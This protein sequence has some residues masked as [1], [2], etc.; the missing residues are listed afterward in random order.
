MVAVIPSE[1]AFKKLP[2]LKS[3]LYSFDWKI[4]IKAPFVEELHSKLVKGFKAFGLKVLS[5]EMGSF[6]R[7]KPAYTLY[8]KWIGGKQYKGLII[9]VDLVLAVKINTHSSTMKV[10]FKSQAGSVVSSLLGTLPCYFAVSGYKEYPVT[11]H[12]TCSRNLRRSRKKESWPDFQYL[13][14]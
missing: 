5:D 10:D 13:S 9:A 7:H 11:A 4:N 14:Q 12:Q 2:K 8:L 3:S 1:S 6:Q